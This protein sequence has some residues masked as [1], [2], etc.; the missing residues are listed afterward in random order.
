VHKQ[1]VVLLVVDEEI[2]VTAL[3]EVVDELE[4]I[5]SAPQAENKIKQNIASIGF[6]ISL[7][8]RSI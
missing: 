5:L 2:L 1:L 8:K 3:L 4:V 7:R 6:M